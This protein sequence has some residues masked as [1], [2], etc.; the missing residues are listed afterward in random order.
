MR[1]RAGWIKPMSPT[2]SVGIPTYNR[3]GLLIQAIQSVLRQTYQDFEIIVS[4]DCSLDDTA[5]VI[6][7]FGDPRI[8]YHRTGTNLRPP[9]NW[10]ECVRLARGEFFALL[11]DDDVY[12]PDFLA[13]MLTVIQAQPQAGFAQCGYYSVDDQL[14]CIQRIQPANTSLTLNAQDALGW[15]MKDLRCVPVALLF[16]RAA[17]LDVGL[18]REKEGY[19]DDWAFIVRL[20]CRHGFIYT[21]EL[22]ACNRVHTKNLNRELHDQGRDAILDL[23]NQQADVFGESL[24][25]TPK[26]EALRA[27]LDRQLSQHCVL[28]ALGALRRR[29]FIQAR[30]HFNRARRLYALAGFDLGFIN[31]RLNLR[32]EAQQHLRRQQAARSLAPV[33]NLDRQP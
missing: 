26:I 17:M 3:S 29:N 12:C 14:R 1:W 31:L 10:N 32:A 8:V 25:L 27:E 2:V 16:R 5:D 11:P 9:R 21:P 19:W 6:R 4:D 20:A 15:Q 23:L 33:I 24:P 22:L 30:V 28:L 13:K 18:W 7:R